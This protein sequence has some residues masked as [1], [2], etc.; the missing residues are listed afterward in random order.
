MTRAENGLGIVSVDVYLF[1]K[2]LIKEMR[3]S[4]GGFTVRE[5]AIVRVT[6]RSGHIGFG[7][8]IGT[9]SS[10]F[11][12]LHSVVAPHALG[13]QVNRMNSWV[14]KW[15]ENPTYFEGLGSV[16]SAVSAIEMAMWDAYGRFLGVPCNQLLGGAVQ[17]KIPAYASDIYWQEDI[18]DMRSEAAR[19]CS[20]GF[21]RV[22]AHIGVLPPREETERVKALRAE[23]GDDRDL[24]LDINCGYDLRAAREAL[25][26]WQDYQ[27]Y[28]VEEPLLPHYR[29]SL[30][31]LTTGSTGTPIAL[32]EN[33]FSVSD[34]AELAQNGSVDVLMPDVGRIGGIQALKRISEVGE[35]LGS[36]V[37]PHNFSSGVLLA[38]TAQV[39]SATN[40][41]NLIEVDTSGNAIYEQ[42]LSPDWLVADGEVTVSSS[43]GLGIQLPSKVLDDYCSKTKH[44]SL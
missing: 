7:E 17:S 41:M 16:A 11:E 42:L 9:A 13:H 38:A 25:V 4:R 5:H 10:I 3:I 6:T 37:S 20:L 1:R 19:I 12:I 29:S 35:A 32:G 14:V 30:A 44:L 40:H 31:S 27:P 21:K 43:P 2:P 34:F 24:M 8:G 15:F 18:D 23:I 28:W 22:K 36:F 26:R 39:M 33:V